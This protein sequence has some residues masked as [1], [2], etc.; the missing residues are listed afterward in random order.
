MCIKPFKSGWS[1]GWLYGDRMVGRILHTVLSTI[2]ELNG[3][4]SSL[5]SL[6]KKWNHLNDIKLSR[7]KPHC[8]K[9]SILRWPGSSLRCG[10]LVIWWGSKD[11]T[12]YPKRGI[13][14]RWSNLV[15]FLPSTQFFVPFSQPPPLLSHSTWT[16]YFL[17]RFMPTYDQWDP[18]GSQV[19][20]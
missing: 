20:T 8:L 13:T 6:P 18:D 15:G 17:I 9:E 16:S 1:A 11:C 12:H 14:T 2:L 5:N 10:L 19:K 7:M 4:K 3:W